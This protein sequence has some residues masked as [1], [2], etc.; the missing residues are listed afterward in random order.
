M[1]HVIVLQHVNIILKSTT[2]SGYKRKV[3]TSDT[4][5]DRELADIIMIGKVERKRCVVGERKVLA[6]E[7]LRVR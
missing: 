4:L 2:N 7:H 1:A 6:K 3:V 5:L